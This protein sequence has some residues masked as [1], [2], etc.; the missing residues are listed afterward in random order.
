MG[1]DIEKTRPEFEA[2]MVAAARERNYQY[3]LRLLLKHDNGDYRTLWV[4]NAWIGWCAA[5][6]AGIACCSGDE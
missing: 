6:A 1:A 2:R 5:I 4:D 3:M